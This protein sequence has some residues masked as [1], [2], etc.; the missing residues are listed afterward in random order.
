MLDNTD[1]N[2]DHNDFDGYIVWMRTM[3]VTTDGYIVLIRTMI[4]T[5]QVDNIQ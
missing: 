4:V 2:H 1:K 5:M 3:I